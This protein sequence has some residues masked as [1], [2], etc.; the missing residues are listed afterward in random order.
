MEQAIARFISGGGKMKRL[1]FI[2]NEEEL[3]NE[4]VKEILS[5]QVK[6]GVETYITDAQKAPAQLKRFFVVETRG[7]I[8]WEVFIGPDNRIVSVV[9][10]S[11]PS[12][13][14]RYARIFQ[15][16]L[17]LEETRRYLG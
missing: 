8:A 14:E 11:D 10:I 2:T 15:E 6:I 1:F 13:T 4:E 17:E 16:S 12:K 3:N 9:A 5:T 7:K